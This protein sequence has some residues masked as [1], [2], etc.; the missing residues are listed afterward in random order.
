M[1]DRNR[2][3]IYFPRLFF[4]HDVFKNRVYFLAVVNNAAVSTS[5][6]V[7][8]VGCKLPRYTYPGAERLG[9]MTALLLTS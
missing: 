1:A 8:V 2:N 5:V 6:R 7:S 3:H 4:K 9:H